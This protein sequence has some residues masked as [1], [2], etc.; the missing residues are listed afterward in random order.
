MTQSVR[1]PGMG[2]AWLPLCLVLLDRD[3][4]AV[5]G[6]PIRVEQATQV[7]HLMGNESGHRL[8]VRADGPDTGRSLVFDL[9]QRRDGWSG[10]HRGCLHVNKKL[11]DQRRLVRIAFP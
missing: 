3:E 9:D 4:P 2:S 10:S 8:A 7:V 1:H 11:S 5:A 6:H